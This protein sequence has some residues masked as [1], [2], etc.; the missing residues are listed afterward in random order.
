MKEE[1]IES[2]CYKRLLPGLGI[3]LVAIEV[4][5][6][7]GGSVVAKN[8]SINPL[9]LLLLKDLLQVSYN[10][11]TS[12][13]AGE[14]P[15]PRGRRLLLLLRG[16]ATGLS[17]MGHFYAVRYLPIADV[18][19]ITSIKPVSITLLSCLLLNEPC[20]LFEIVNLALVLSGIFLV[21]QPPFIFES[22]EM[23]Y[24]PHMFYTALGLLATQCLAATTTIILRYLRDM[25]WAALAISSRIVNILEVLAFCTYMQIFCLPQCGLERLGVLL[26]A[27]FGF[28]QQILHIFSLK[29]EEAHLVGLVQNSLD[30]L[31]S[32]I[33]Q[34]IF[35]HTFP[36]SCKLVGATLIFS[37]VVLVG[38]NKARKAKQKHL[39]ERIKR[40]IKCEKMYKKMLLRSLATFKYY[41]T[42]GLRI[43]VHWSDRQTYKHTFI[44]YQQ[45]QK[46]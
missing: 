9:L 12:L 27:V 20:G 36:S 2:R 4:I 7:Q 14:D 6:F 35:F 8:L 42:Q 25:H 5:V 37:S 30:I 18:A 29:L 19:M 3:L 33:F 39:P 16:A 40:L 21:V 45:W 15:F 10:V 46:K 17:F 22:S 24:T 28:A 11:P 34:I 31:V 41:F 43:T 44:L 38:V 23:E 13:I 32:F 1:N 26:L